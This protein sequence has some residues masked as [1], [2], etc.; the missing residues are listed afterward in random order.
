VDA[1]GVRVIG[2]G[3]GAL[4]ALF[5]AALDARIQ[6]VVCD[7]GLLSYRSLTG[8]DRYLHE[9]SI[10]IPGVLRNFDLPQVASAIAGRPLA[11]LAPVDA[12]KKPV[13]LGIARQAYEWTQAV[14]MVA[15]AADRFQ[16]VGRS[17]KIDPADQYLDLLSA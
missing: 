4:W 12:M 9:A 13:E 14:Y 8:T 1:G 2:K 6:N 3:M 16:I 11:L 5:A 15:G 17:E 7:S 10:F